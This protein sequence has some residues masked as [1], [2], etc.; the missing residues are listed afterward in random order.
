MLEQRQS[1]IPILDLSRLWSPVYDPDA[2]TLPKTSAYEISKL[3]DSS[4]QSSLASQAAS[5]ELSHAKAV[6]QIKQ[7]RGKKTAKPRAR[8]HQVFIAENGIKVTVTASSKANYHEV[9]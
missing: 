2:G 5:G 8:L 7:R 6:K 4:Q 1:K 3:T 9:E